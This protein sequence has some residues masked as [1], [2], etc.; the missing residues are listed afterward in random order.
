[1]RFRGRCRN[2]GPLR[3]LIVR[4]WRSEIQVLR[5]V[6]A[7]GL[8]HA[9]IGAETHGICG[10]GVGGQRDGDLPDV[11][12]LFSILLLAVEC[13]Q[14]AALQLGD[15]GIDG[16]AAGAGVVERPLGHLIHGGEELGLPL[17]GG[18]FG[19]R[20]QQP[21]Q[22]GLGDVDVLLQLLT[23]LDPILKGLLIGFALHADQLA[24][25]HVALEGLRILVLGEGAHLVG[26]TL[27]IE[28]AD[29]GEQQGVGGAVRDVEQLVAELA[30]D[31]KAREPEKETHKKNK[32]K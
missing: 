27:G 18:L 3:E 19:M 29:E 23:G 24:Q 32:E 6:E 10:V 16:V 15:G 26:M 22:N 13:L 17:L 2:T 31:A 21:V 8:F 12:V 7:A 9:Q 11:A 25:L 30:N 28:A 20:L 5:L 4:I 14:V 1:M